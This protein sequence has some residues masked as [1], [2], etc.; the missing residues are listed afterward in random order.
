MGKRNL[1][2]R[3]KRSNQE[4]ERFDFR[5][6]LH[7]IFLRFYIAEHSF[8]MNLSSS[9]LLQHPNHTCTLTLCIW[10][11]W[12]RLTSPSLYAS[13]FQITSGLVLHKIKAVKTS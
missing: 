2:R 4:L 12:S 9:T 1:H 8:S 6:G 10:P 7:F 11:S 5:S 3:G 13:F